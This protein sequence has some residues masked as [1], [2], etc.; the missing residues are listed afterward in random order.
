[1]RKLQDRHCR[2]S[3]ARA[4]QAKGDMDPS[5]PWRY[6][7]AIWSVCR[8]KLMADW[9]PVSPSSPRETDVVEMAEGW[10]ASHATDASLAVVV[11][12]LHPL[13]RAGLCFHWD[14]S[15]PL[16]LYL[17]AHAYD[18]Q[19]TRSSSWL[20]EHR[21]MAPEVTICACRGDD[22]GGFAR[23]PASPGA[24]TPVGELCPNGTPSVTN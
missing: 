19:S 3:S 16:L 7:R 8:L 21:K 2:G 17:F 1:M 18:I 4:E 5:P 22:Q 20:H 9:S 14:R 23:P 13:S 12:G 6:L 24:G 10:M 11:S 15:R